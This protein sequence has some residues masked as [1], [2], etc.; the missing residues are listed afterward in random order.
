MIKGKHPTLLKV[1]YVRPNR[2][3]DQKECFQVLYNDDDG[4]VQ[5][6]EEPGEADI[7]IT[8]P[9]FRDHTYNKPEER[10]ERMDKIRVPISQIRYKIAKEAGDWGKAL[11]ERATNEHDFKLL[12]QV[13][14]W[15]YCYGC[16]FQPEFY[17]MK[18]WYAKYELPNAPV[19][20]KAFMDIETDLMDYTIDMDHIRDSA[21]APVNVVVVIL[22]ATKEAYQFILRPYV[23]PR[24]GRTQ[25]EYDER[26]KMYEKQLAA[27]NYLMGHLDEH[28]EK[29]HK[30]FDDTYGYLDY[31]IREYEKEIELI[32]DVFRLINTK[33]PNFCLI[34]NMRFDIQYLYW[35]IVT[36]GYDPISIMCH[37]DI[38]NPTCYFQEDRFTFLIEKQYDFFHCT[39]WTQYLCQ[40]RNYASVRKSQHKLRSVALNAIADRELRDK[41][42]EYPENANIVRFPYENWPLFIQYNLKDSLLQ[43]G[44]ERKT[45]D[46]ETYYNRSHANLTPYNKIYRETHL[47]RNVREMY[48]ERAGWVQG[49]NLNT[50]GSDGDE[51]ADQFYGRKKEPKEKASFKGAI[52]AE[53]TMN[54]H[55]GE[56]VLGVR[57]NNI[58]HLSID[59]D[60]GSF[61]PSIKIS[62]NMDPL[63]LLFKAA[64]INDEFSS[65][66]FTNRSQNQEYEEK[67]KNGNM[68]QV[69]I[70]GEAVNT[71]AG[72]NVLTFGYNFLNLPS[73]AQVYEQVKKMSG[74]E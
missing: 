54:M 20:T 53:P 12:D 63:T 60:M 31:H 49:N 25:E 47:L 32:A 28:Y 27:H 15:P 21:N 22:E 7:W 69:D 6:S 30:E 71:Y 4:N 11:L 61:Y 26:Y 36:L 66:E 17:F 59:F 52:N 68:R 72:G 57:S 9:E 23:P 10:M 13:Y 48:F 29:I 8:K 45:K 64:F 73:V 74:G 46:L 1:T 33:K 35:R 67:D 3:I 37:P 62:S 24:N 70:T 5:F 65:G 51:T 41:K 19:L 43:M 50:I 2:K 34:W 42:V 58:F 38:P 55:I 16:D 14:R 56:P 18:D 39:S 44:I 40:M